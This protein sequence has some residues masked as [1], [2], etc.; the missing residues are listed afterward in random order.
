MKRLQPVQLRNDRAQPCEAG[1][2][3]GWL[4]KQSVSVTSL[5]SPSRVFSSEMGLASF[6]LRGCPFCCLCRL[7]SCCFTGLSW[8][9]CCLLYCVFS[10]F[11][12]YLE[13]FQPVFFPFLHFLAVLLFSFFLSLL[14][15]LS[16]FFLSYPSLTP[17]CLVYRCFCGYFYAFLLAT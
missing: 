9:F 13:F 2:D 14:L 11:L 15:L 3:A 8:S 12:V 1:I 17:A 10:F 6:L 4:V 7:Y 16:P 5:C